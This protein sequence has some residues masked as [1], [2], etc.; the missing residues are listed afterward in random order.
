YRAWRNERAGRLGGPVDP[1]GT[2]EQRHDAAFAAEPLQL[3]RH[4]QGGLLRA[5]AP[6]ATAN[7]DHWLTARDHA[8][9]RARDPCECREMSAQRAAYVV[10]LAIKFAPPVHRIAGRGGSTRGGVNCYAVITD[11]E[12]VGTREQRVAG[13][14]GFR[15]LSGRPALEPLADRLRRA[16]PQPAAFE[17]AHRLGKGARVRGGGSGTDR[18]KVV[19][20]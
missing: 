12:I 11:H 13:L 9:A 8:Y 15:D 3:E 2:G 16:A 20:R 5:P 4:R 7:R 18:R 17:H 10:G 6:P 1:V 19:M 14:Y